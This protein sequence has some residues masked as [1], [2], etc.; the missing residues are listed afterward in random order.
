V[1][2]PPFDLLLDEHGPALHRFLISIVGRDAA[3][4]CF[5]DTVV[6]ALRGY[7]ELRD[8][9][10]LRAWLFAVAHSRA[11]DGRRKR[12]RDPVAADEVP[13]RTAPPPSEPDDLLWQAVRC[14]P[15]KQREAV[16]LRFVSDLPYRDIGAVIG[17]SEAAARQNVRAGLQRLREVLT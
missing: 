5:Q 15:D 13:E 3:A 14:L 7:D 4:D 9:R 2:L 8:D 1:N 6:T 11:L 12:A 16:V 10:N 17:C